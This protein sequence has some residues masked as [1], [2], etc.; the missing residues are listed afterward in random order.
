MSYSVVKYENGVC[1]LV[2]KDTEILLELKCHYDKARDICRK[3]NL[4]SGFNGWTPQFLAKKI[5]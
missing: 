3:L 4:G 5:S 2:E 1:D